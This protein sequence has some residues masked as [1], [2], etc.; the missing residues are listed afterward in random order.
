MKK[1]ILKLGF[2]V[3]CMGAIIF[4]LLPFLETTT[5]ASSELQAGQA[6]AVTENPLNAI[7]RRLKSLFG[8]KERKQLVASKTADPAT[9]QT[10]VQPNPYAL[11]RPAGNA[12]GNAATSAT[13]PNNS[14]TPQTVGNENSDQ[15]YENAAFQTDEGEW[16]LIRQ[17]APQH[18]APG[19]HEVNVHEN[20]YDRYI[21]QERAR[22]FGPQVPQ[23]EIPSSKWARLIQP[24]QAFFGIESANPVEASKVQVHQNTEKGNVLSS[25]SDKSLSSSGSSSAPAYPRASLPDITPTQ[26]ALLTP[27]ERRERQERYAAQNF[28]DLLTGERAA[29]EAAKIVADA[30]ISNPQNAKEE[31]KKEEIEQKAYE[32]NMS[33]IREGVMAKIK[34]HAKDFTQVDE[35]SYMVGC[36]DTSIPSE[37]SACGLE[38]DST[39]SQHL[40]TKQLQQAQ[41]KNAQQ[42]FD[43]TKFVLPEGLPFTVVV[44]PTKDASIFEDMASNP[45][46][47]QTG[48]IYQ[49]MYKQ[50]QCASQPCYWLPNAQQ[51]DVQLTDA[52]ATVGGAHLKAD[53]YNTYDTYR[54]AF[55]QQ[56]VQQLG[57]DATDQ[58]KQQIRQK[59]LEQWD[60]K[61]TNW[62]PYKGE[63]L[64]QLT[65]D[66][67]DALS[68]PLDQPS[69][70]QPV[71]PLVTDPAVAP[72]LAELIGPLS[73]VY[74]QVSLTNVDNP[75]DAGEEVT[76]SIA[77]NINDTKKVVENV[78]QE[79]ITEGLQSSINQAISNTNKQGQGFGGLL[80]A[81]RNLGNRPQTPP[82]K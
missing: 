31:Q 21:R 1:T 58:Q 68:T 59:A 4:L 37:H 56:K 28:H 38:E 7:A 50:Q 60:K 20:P 36:K 53:P 76:E 35:L 9:P 70:K 24:V 33:K 40:P 25:A 22:S 47:A 41:A 82:S 32:Q 74:N 12:T 72:E 43:Q 77:Q 44:G 11:Y 48:E 73:F 61:R 19:M 63:Q 17:T 51:P 64:I 2:I 6:Q 8:K 26:W 45:S 57:P 13:G 79:A 54:E 3:L 69:Q 66:N 29:R 15:A 23:Q 46:T 10:A 18:S 75:I 80:E 62:V 14:A 67:K 65:Q 55:V 16:V 27:Q 71:F 49:F 52:L 81:V 78:Q 30:Q 42:F 39:S 34:E 5:P